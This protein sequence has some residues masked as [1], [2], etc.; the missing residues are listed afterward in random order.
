MA[1]GLSISADNIDRFTE[2]FEAVA[3]TELQEEDL[4]PCAMHDGEV[5]LAE[6]SMAQVAELESLSPFGAGN[7][8]PTFVSLGCRV[9]APR[10]LGEKHLKFDVEQNGCRLACIAFG[11][12]ERFDQLGGA[13]DLL[14]R[15]GI[16]S[17][18][19][20][21]SVQLQIADFRPAT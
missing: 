16:N 3:R 10:V 11:M 6:L 20:N 7:P 18:R 5:A 15:P 2:L 1:A 12:A 14:Y 21:S 8:Q 9:L 17:F 4:L 19:G 13:I